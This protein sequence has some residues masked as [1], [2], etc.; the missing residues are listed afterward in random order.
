MIKYVY[1]FYNPQIGFL[2]TWGTNFEARP[3]FTIEVPFCVIQIF[4]R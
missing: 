3:Y 4:L 2:I 1:A